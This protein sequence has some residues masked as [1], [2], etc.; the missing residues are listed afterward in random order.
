MISPAHDAQVAAWPGANSVLTLLG[1]ES[2]NLNARLRYLPK[3]R[4]YLRY[5]YQEKAV[6]GEKAKVELEQN[7]ENFHVMLMFVGDKG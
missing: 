4:H 1:E 6:L 7:H 3:L 5:G 2:S